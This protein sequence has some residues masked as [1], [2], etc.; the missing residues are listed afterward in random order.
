MALWPWG[1]RGS[2]GGGV[3]HGVWLVFDR[4]VILYTMN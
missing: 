1:G 2:S 3:G 4:F